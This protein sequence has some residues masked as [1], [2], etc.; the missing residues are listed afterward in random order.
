M[1]HKFCDYFGFRDTRPM[2]KFEEIDIN[3]VEDNSKISDKMN[4]SKCVAEWVNIKSEPFVCLALK[5]SPQKNRLRKKN[6]TFDF[7]MCDQIFDSLLQEKHI[8]L[9]GHHVIPSC[10]ELG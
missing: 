8:R 10:E 5:P 7:N 4:T 9:L 3:I 2:L 1:E 6:Y